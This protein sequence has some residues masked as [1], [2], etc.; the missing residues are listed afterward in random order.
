MDNFDSD[1]LKA[2]NL[3]IQDFIFKKLPYEVVEEYLQTKVK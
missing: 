2:I 1:D 3:K